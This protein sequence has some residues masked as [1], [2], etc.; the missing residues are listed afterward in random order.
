M[1]CKNRKKL[2]YD[3]MIL[4]T[5]ITT[6]EF[7]WISGSKKLQKTHTAVQISFTN[8]QSDKGMWFDIWSFLTCILT[9]AMLWLSVTSSYNSWVWPEN[10]KGMFT[11]TLS[12]SSSLYIVNPW[13]AIIESLFSQKFCSKW[14]FSLQVFVWN[15]VCNHL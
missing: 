9:E 13:S 7:P 8:P 5:L 11:F 14:S 4:S 2:K 12:G 10:N 3:F 1:I 15:R 6:A